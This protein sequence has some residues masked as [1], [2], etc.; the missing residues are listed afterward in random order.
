MNLFES[1]K[2]NLTETAENFDLPKGYPQEI[3]DAYFEYC[4]DIDLVDD[5]PLDFNE[6]YAKEYGKNESVEELEPRFDSRASFYGKAKVDTNGDE[7]TLISYQTPILKIKDGNIEVLCDEDDLSQTTMRHVR[8]FLKQM[9]WDNKINLSGKDYPI[10]KKWL[11]ARKNTTQSD[12][13]LNES[14]NMEPT[15]AIKKDG[16]PYNDGSRIDPRTGERF[17]GKTKNEEF[18]AFVDNQLRSGAI[19]DPEYVK[20]L[21]DEEYE[22]LL[23]NT[24]MKDKDMIDAYNKLHESD[25]SGLFDIYTLTRNGNE[26]TSSLY[27]TVEDEEQANDIVA[28]LKAQGI[29]AYV[30][31]KKPNYV[32]FY[33]NGKELG[34]HDLAN[35][36]DGERE[37]A[38][39]LFASENNVKPE[40][41]EVKLVY[42]EAESTEDSMIRLTAYGK[43][44][45]MFDKDEWNNMSDEERL[46]TIADV[47][48]QATEEEGHTVETDE[49]EVLMESEKL[50][51]SDSHIIWSS[52]TTEDDYD[53]EELKERYQEYVDEFDGTRKALSYEEW[54]DS[55]WLYN[56][57]YHEFN[58]AENEYDDWSDFISNYDDETLKVYYKDYV[59]DLN[60]LEPEQPISFE[61]WKENYIIDDSSDQW[62]FKKEDLEENIYPMIDKQIN[63]D[64]LFVVGNYN[65]NYPDFRP[66]GKGGK[67]LNKAED[68]L[69][70]LSNN[71]RVD[72]SETSDGTIEVSSYDHDGG[73]DGLLYTFPD[74]KDLLYKV[75][76]E[77]DY[78]EE[79]RDIDDVLGE[80]QYDINHGNIDMSDFRGYEDHFIP[81]KVTWHETMRESA[82]GKGLNDLAGQETMSS[83]V[84][85]KIFSDNKSSGITKEVIIER[86]KKLIDDNKTNGNNDYANGVHDGILDMV[87]ALEIDITELNE[88]FIN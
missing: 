69:D 86:A 6:W 7:Y 84:A 53:P 33:L 85:D 67:F 45:Y 10:T 65:S 55:D 11:M 72:F 68:I 12:T 70:W 44:Y 16:T 13:D 17:F 52:E 26:H 46:N 1:I 8:D 36:F 35:E 73:I 71:D 9:D 51:E 76:M 88:D 19:D 74:D 66:S 50:K 81:I 29:N 83:E 18:R 20:S 62:T 31:T 14:D 60:E 64:I 37:S 4:K 54:L 40:D 43:V 78:Y 79:D 61:D 58:S 21:S 3:Y 87:Q 80:F 56:Y 15:P 38:R 5:E 75:A 59:D 48:D 2:S 82:L 41:I 32:M 57:L 28:E 25:S 42:K 23:T 49:V 47:A 22:N 63:N 77:T 27:K 30:D 24:W 34:G 39:E